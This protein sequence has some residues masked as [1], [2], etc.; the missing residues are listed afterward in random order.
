MNPSLGDMFVYTVVNACFAAIMFWQTRKITKRLDKHLREEKM[1]EPLVK[2]AELVLIVINIVLDMTEAELRQTEA[3]IRFR[4][5][6]IEKGK[7][8]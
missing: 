6:A 1:D 8:K 2:D 7:N 4:R 3:A 5:V